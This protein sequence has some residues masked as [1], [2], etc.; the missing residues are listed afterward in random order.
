MG[1]PCRVELTISGYGTD[2]REL[3][4][5]PEVC[6]W[7]RR[8]VRDVPVLP[9]FL[10]SVSLDRLAGWLCGPHSTTAFSDPKFPEKFQAARTACVV[11]AVA[12]SSQFLARLGADNET[13]SRLYSQILNDRR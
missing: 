6:D 3:Y 10:T 2:P 13:L 12:E 7:A 9:F 5:I 4:E 8:T 11:K 1:K